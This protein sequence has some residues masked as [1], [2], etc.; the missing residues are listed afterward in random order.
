MNPP[1]KPQQT[2]EEKAAQLKRNRRQYRDRIKLKSTEHKATNRHGLW[3]AAIRTHEEV[4]AI[5]GLSS[6]RTRQ[7]EK[8]ALFKLRRALKDHNPFIHGTAKDDDRW[9]SYQRSPWSE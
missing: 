3:C 6:E 1:N 2:S 9:Q 8:E 4:A 7:I 5:M